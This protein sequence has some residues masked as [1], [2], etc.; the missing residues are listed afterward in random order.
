MAAFNKTVI[1]TILD[2]WGI[3]PPGSG[4]AISRAKLPNFKSLLEN[5]PN[6]QLEAAG[7][8]VGLPAGAAGNSE[9]GH[10]NLGAGRIVQQD[11]LRINQSI[12]NGRFFQN[13]VFLEAIAHAKKNNSA[14][15]LLGLI[16]KG[17]VHASNKHLFALLE[18][19]KKQNFNRVFIHL[20]TD[21]RD[22]PPQSALTFI[23]KLEKFIARLQIGQIASIS[24]RY[25]AMDRDHRWKRTEKVY[26]ALTEGKGSLAPSANNAVEQAYSKDQTDEFILPTLIIKNQKP[27]ALIKNNDALIFYN[28]RIDRARQ[29]SRAFVLPDFETRTYKTAFD[30][31]KNES[32]LE[33]NQQKKSQ[34]PFTR[35]VVLK[36]LFFVSMTEY[37]KNLPTKI[38]FPEQ[39]LK[40]C[41]GEV[42]AHAG[43]KQLRAAETEKE[44]FVT[45]YFNGF[46]EEPFSNEKRLIV[47]SPQVKTYDLQPEM[48]AY[49]LCE[50][51]LEALE[52]ENYSFA[53]IN[54]ANPDMVA[55]TGK[56]EPT[57]KAC[58][59]VDEC[60]GGLIDFALSN[61]ISLLVTA[62]H[63]NAEELI[64][65]KT[66]E[67]NTEHSDSLVPF[68]YVNKAWQGQAQQLPRGI[69][70]DVA[71]TI[72][73]LLK[74]TKP[75]LMTGKSLINQLLKE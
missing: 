54:F 56:I 40:Q 28:F 30:I 73:E 41:L 37:E 12:D 31:Y 33:N 34:P 18:L 29:L 39:S 20:F 24:G 63:G 51:F 64:D 10:L 22:S 26:L 5:F 19:A 25:Y 27:L 74:L 38:A 66:G 67:V 47:P 59:A 1:L 16:G 58:E 60:L 11:V 17:L 72:L 32:P 57:I 69:L 48:S 14:L 44:R 21:G 62:D 3:A 43:S 55:H 7:K 2:G 35:Q 68:I 53:V 52:K 6:T 61:Q 42:I 50:K 45:Y 70:G 13:P 36:N 23:E 4:N 9:V 65:T 8:A 49:L 15:H 75:K 46:K 71:P